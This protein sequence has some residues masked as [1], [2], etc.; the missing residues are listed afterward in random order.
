MSL[1]A[2]GNRVAIGAPVEPGI[3]GNGTAR[4]Y[5]WNGTA[6]NL[7]G[8]DIE[9]EANQDLCGTSVSMSGDGIRMAVGAPGN[10]EIGSNAG[11]V[12]IYVIE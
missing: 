11:H 5:E 4:I 10:D 9:G 1:S 3:L 7:L 8:N 12:R 2:D 6:W